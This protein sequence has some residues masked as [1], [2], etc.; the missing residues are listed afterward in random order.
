[1]KGIRDLK[2]SSESN[3]NTE[4]MV[5]NNNPISKMDQEI[6]QNYKI[7]VFKMEEEMRNVK[8]D[9]ESLKRNF[10]A[11]TLKGKMDVERIKQLEEELSILVLNSKL[12]SNQPVEKKQDD[13][14]NEKLDKL[15]QKYIDKIKQLSDKMIENL[16][17]V[18]KEQMFAK[19]SSAVFRWL[20]PHGQLNTVRMKV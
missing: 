3:M 9:Y 16:K 5:D 15:E 19:T 13:Y 8:D 4:R 12:N 11:L 7:K 14:Y 1:M 18:I 20:K 6:I 10:D 2:R 17:D